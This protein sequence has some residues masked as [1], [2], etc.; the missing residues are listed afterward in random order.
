[1]LNRLIVEAT[2]CDFKRELEKKKPKSWLKSVSAFANGA[3]GKAEF[4]DGKATIA[5]EIMG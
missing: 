2:E 5:Q 3:I 4:A 1:M